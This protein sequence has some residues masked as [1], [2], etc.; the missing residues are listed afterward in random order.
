MEASPVAAPGAGPGYRE[1][2]RVP[3]FR[4]LWFAHVTSG[5]GDQVT[6]VALASLVLARTGSV[7]LSAMSFTLTFLPW[8]LGGPVLGVLADRHPRRTVMVTCDLGRGLVVGVMALA[9]VPVWGLFALG[10]FAALLSPPFEAARGATVPDVLTPR[11]YPVGQ[12]LSMAGLQV[13]QLLGFALGGLLVSVRPGAEVLGV[14]AASFL[15]SAAVLRMCCAWRPGRLAP[16]AAGGVGRAWLRATAAG[17]VVVGGSVELR[18]L[19]TISCVSAAV[20]VVPEGVAVA[21]ARAW[22]ASA[23]DAGLLCAALP[24][25][26]A[27]GAVALGRW[28]SPRRRL[29]LVRPLSL[30]AGAATGA[31]VLGP[32]LAG[33][34]VL[35]LL[36]GVGAAGLL[37]ANVDFVMR[38]APGVRGRGLSLAQVALQATQGIALTVAG[39]LASH[40][41]PAVAVGMVGLAGCVA[42]AVLSCRWPPGLDVAAPD[43]DPVGA[44]PAVVRRGWSPAA[45]VW[46]LTGLVLGLAWLLWTTNTPM[47]PASPGP[48]RLAWWALL[49]LVLAAQAGVVHFQVRRQ[50]Q[51]VTLCHL[52]IVLGLLCCA[53][54]DFVVARVLG[55]LLGMALLRRQRGVKLVLN[56][57]SYTLEAVTAVVLLSHLRSWQLPAALYL[58]MIAADITS[59]MVVS[60]AIMLFERRLRAATWLKPLLWLLPINL[61]TTSVALLAAAALWRGIGYLPLLA[62]VLTG[63]LLFYRTYSRLRDRHLDLGR[64]KDFAASLPPLTPG[65]PDLAAAVESARVLLFAERMEL[66]LAQGSVVLAEEGR[67]PV[68]EPARQP[69]R[70]PAPARGRSLRRAAWSSLATEVTHDGGSGSATLVARERLGA[71]RLF[72][73]DDDRLLAAVG[74]LIAGGLGRGWDR[75]RALDAAS[76]DPLTGLWTLPEAA[77]RAGRLLAAGAR[78]GLLIID[79]IGLQDVNDSLGHDAGDA[80]LQLTGRRLQAAA[81]PGAVTA[82]IG[83]DEFLAVL[84]RDGP[85]P[86]QVVRDLGGQ[87]DLSG[88]QIDLRVR[89]GFCAWEKDTDTF[90]QLLR[91]AQAAMA[92]AASGGTRYRVWSPELAVDPTRRLRL[93]GD[94]QLA[95]ARGEV[96][97][98]FQPLCRASNLTVVGAEA[99]AR[100]RHPELGQVPPDEFIA[101]AEQTG[102]ISELT[103]VVLDAA[104]RQGRRWHDDGHHLRVSVNLSPR[105]LGDPDLV[106]DVCAVLADHELPATAL[107][108]EITE[109]SVMDDLAHGLG[110]LRALRAAGIEVAIDDFGTGHSSLAQLRTLPAGEVKLDRSLLADMATDPT[111]HRIVQTAVALCQDLGKTVVAEGVED[112]ATAELLR[113]CGVDVL[114]GYHLGRPLPAALWDPRLLV[115]GRPAGPTLPHQADPA[116]ALPA[117]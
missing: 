21:Q 15:L 34:L 80:L 75:Q 30:V 107:L 93:A 74:G 64:L 68:E 86:E 51:T 52:P 31:T 85:G 10:A 99:L 90:Q 72:D 115:P 24:A 117:P 32:D 1:V 46:I 91:Q 82:R 40:L 61:V 25:G 55:G 12:S 7:A 69:A 96:T 29:G 78:P 103:R 88:P 22:G 65:G 35:W 98:V 4:A 37:P 14:D 108:L 102:L 67:A 101:I 44:R 57:A 63:L 77:R 59:F 62:G 83:G 43:P 11:Q 16:P 111:A 47:S 48:L 114:Q 81:G 50:A 113:A 84:G 27:I 92:R 73:E 41:G 18:R 39:V 110:V 53:P 87:F 26:T 94:L 109:N 38:L 5:V 104:L 13:A 9:A 33:T 23:L 70:D 45:P 17:A 106:A 79:I 105:S 2:L 60:L 100:W 89:A 116:Y 71:V 97:V 28:V 112:Q 54:G 66:W 95:L 6:R 56:T 36:A 8:L 19:L 42:A 49:P 58:V 76:R 3:E 20:A